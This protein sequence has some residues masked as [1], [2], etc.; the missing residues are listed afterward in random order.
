MEELAKDDRQVIGSNDCGGMVGILGE[1]WFGGRR[2][3]QL[4]CGEPRDLSPARESANSFEKA[5]RQREETKE[6]V[7]PGWGRRTH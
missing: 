4:E 6:G 5:G 7:S 1:N 3:V 2:D